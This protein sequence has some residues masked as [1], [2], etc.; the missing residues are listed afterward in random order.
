MKR[1]MT[2]NETALNIIFEDQHLLVIDKPA[3]MVVHP[4]KGHNRDTLVALLLKR[5]PQFSRF[6]RQDRAGVVHRLDKD[7]SGLMI[8]A[9]SEEV[10]LSLIQQFASR[11]VY[12]TYLALVDGVM[13]EPRGIIEGEIGQD[14][15][16]PTKMAVVEGGRDA[17]TRFVV[18]EVRGDRTLIEAMPES[19][20]THQ[21]RVHLAAIG[22]PVSGDRLYGRKSLEVP[23]LF[24]HSARLL[25]KHPVTGTNLELSSSLPADL[26]QVLERLPKR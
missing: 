21:I 11:S 1:D 5:Y 6:P 25:F 19:G 15:E 24:L 3:G 4:A 16:E 7:T 26:K 14:P 22:H 2:A 17:R 18:V 9:K 13:T 20:R 8:V 12:K 10:Q 23:R